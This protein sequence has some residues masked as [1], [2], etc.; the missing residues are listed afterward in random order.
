MRVHVCGTRGSTPAPGG[1]FLRYGGHTS[2]IALGHD[3]GPPTLF[4][5]AGT[6]IREAGRLMQGRP[7][8]GSILLGHLHW[9]HVQGLPFFAG[10]D[11]P[12]ARTDLYMPAQGDAEKVLERFMSPPFFPITPS[13]MKG[14][15]RFLSIE[16]GETEIEGFTV[17]A[18]DI[19]HRGGRTMGYRVTTAGASVCYM[20]D[21]C[22]TDIGGGP[23]GLGE[24]HQAALTLAKD[25]D[26]M[27]H[28]SQYTDHELPERSFYGHSSCGYAVGLA[29]TAGVKKILMFHHDPS[30]TDEQVDALVKEYQRDGVEVAAAAQGMVVD[31]P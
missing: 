30:R 15:W 27:F 6:G 18:L 11:D 10:S 1:D 3:D 26:V 20:S 24:Y 16:E 23:G 25:C 21:H 4:L 2:C 14:T 31:I 29:A 19:P 17:L 12:A 5:D 9:D 13:Q 8:N 28:D 7:F 22:P